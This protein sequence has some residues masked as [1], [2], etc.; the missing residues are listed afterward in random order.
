MV[1][2]HAS[3]NA[4]RFALS[5]LRA[6]GLV[7]RFQGIGTIVVGDMPIFVSLDT[8]IGLTDLLDRE[9]GR[10][11][12]DNHSA[13]ATT[14]SPGLARH[15]EI[16]IGAGVVFLERVMFLDERPLTLRS[17]WM[18]AAIAQPLLTGE[19]DLQRSIFEVL[20]EGL[21]LRL[22][23]TEYSIEATLA[24]EA[25]AS[26]MKVPI[27]SPVSLS[28]SFTRLADGRAIEYG[29]ARSPGDRIRLV[30][31][32]RRASTDRRTEQ[33]S[34]QMLEPSR[35]DPPL[36]GDLLLVGELIAGRNRKDIEGEVP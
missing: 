29:Y 1:E 3:R 11:R 2:E 28:E 33:L 20:E 13:F 26:V 10:V 27:G 9:A 22:G 16:A 6:E 17:S 36:G 4:V 35:E 25:V 34:K 14:A 15:L 32:T 5:L 18:P 21:G 12:F 7:D 19:V 30:T 31:N 23:A 24:D 8:R